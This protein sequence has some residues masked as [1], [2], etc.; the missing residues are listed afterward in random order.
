M[1]QTWT[2]LI[3][4]YPRNARQNLNDVNILRWP[5]CYSEKHGTNLSQ[6]DSN[7]HWPVELVSVSIEGRTP[8]VWRWCN[9]SKVKVKLLIH[10]PATLCVIWL[11]RAQ[12]RIANTRGR[13]RGS[14]WPNVYNSSDMCRADLLGESQHRP[15]LHRYENLFTTISVRQAGILTQRSV[16]LNMTSSFKIVLTS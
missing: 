13:T 4:C 15:V 5:Y 2:T 3:F 7:T 10:G 14:S 6:P 11:A 9:T 16:T 8:V 1:H 12:W